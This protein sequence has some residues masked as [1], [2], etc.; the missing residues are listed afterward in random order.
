MTDISGE[1]YVMTQKGSQK[2]TGEH[3]VMNPMVFKSFEDIERY[4]K[5]TYIGKDLGWQLENSR[6]PK[7]HGIGLISMVIKD[8]EKVIRRAVFFTFISKVN[9]YEE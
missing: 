5:E 2:Q 8:K 7:W 6:N 9:S 1:V 4:I 3:G